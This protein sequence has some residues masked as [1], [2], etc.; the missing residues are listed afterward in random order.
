MTNYEIIINN[1]KLGFHSPVK[2]KKDRQYAIFSPF[3]DEDGNYRDSGWLD[4]VKDAKQYIGDCCDY[5]LQDIKKESKNWTLLKP[6]FFPPEISVQEGDKVMIMSNA[7]SECERWGW[8]WDDKMKKMVGKVLEIKSVGSN[9]V[10][11]WNKDKSD[12]L[13]FPKTSICYSFKK[14]ED[15][16]KKDI[17]TVNGVKYKRID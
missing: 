2:D 10:N 6:I 14:Q 4:S 16:T 15:D 1:L 17:I 7:E 12:F 13:I 8:D 5:S 3:K 9:I 11:V